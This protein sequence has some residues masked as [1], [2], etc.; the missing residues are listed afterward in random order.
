M[1]R[2]II[3][4]AALL[5]IFSYSYS[6]T[7]NVEFTKDESTT[8][9]SYKSD[10]IK[11]TSD[12]ANCK[13]NV[14]STALQSNL[15]NKECGS[16]VE[17]H[18]KNYGE[19]QNLK[20]VVW[21]DSAQDSVTKTVNVRPCKVMETEEESPY[22]IFTFHSICEVKHMEIKADSEF[23]L[24][25][26]DYS[27][28][29]WDD[30]H[31]SVSLK[32]NNDDSYLLI[33]TGSTNP[34]FTFNVSGQ[35]FDLD[36]VNELS[37]S[38]ENFTNSYSCPGEDV[39]LSLDSS[40]HVFNV[41][42]KGSTRYP[43]KINVT[44][45]TAGATYSTDFN[46]NFESSG[47]TF[48]MNGLN[49][50]IKIYWTDGS[51]TIVY[52]DFIYNLNHPPIFGPMNYAIEYNLVEQYNCFDRRGLPVPCESNY[53]IKIKVRDPGVPL[54]GNYSL[55]LNVTP[56][57]G[58]YT[59]VFATKVDKG[60]Y[61][62]NFGFDDNSSELCNYTAYSDV[63]CS[64]IGSTTICTSKSQ[65]DIVYIY[66]SG[67]VCAYNLTFQAP[68][69]R[70]IS[71]TKY[72]NFSFV[73]IP[74]HLSYG[75]YNE[76]Q[77]IKKEF[78]LNPNE[79][80]YRLI[81]GR[82]PQESG[83]I[84]VEAIRYRYVWK[85]T[86]LNW[87]VQ[88][89]LNNTLVPVPVGHDQ[90]PVSSALAQNSPCTGNSNCY[91]DLPFC[92]D[93]VCDSNA[94]ENCL[95]CAVDCACAANTH[96]CFGLPNVKGFT[97]SHGCIIGYIGYE[98]NCS[99]EEMCDKSKGLTCVFDT[100]H[101]K[102]AMGHCCKPGEIWDPDTPVGFSDANSSIKGTCRVPRG[103]EIT[104]VSIN[105][106]GS[107][108]FG[109]VCGEYLEWVP[110]EKISVTVNVENPQGEDK[111]CVVVATEPYECC[112]DNTK[113]DGGAEIKCK[114]V[115]EG[116]NTFTFYMNIRA[117]HVGCD[118]VWWDCHVERRC[119]ANAKMMILAFIPFNDSSF[120]SEAT[121][122]SYYY[123]DEKFNDIWNLVNQTIQDLEDS[124]NGVGGSGELEYYGPADI[125]AADGQGNTAHESSNDLVSNIDIVNGHSGNVLA[126]TG[127]HY[128]WLDL[129]VVDSS[130]T[131]KCSNKRT[132][133]G[134]I[135][136]AYEY[137]PEDL[138]NTP[139][140]GKF[141]GRFVCGG[142]DWW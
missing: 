37:Y 95:T 127:G 66:P 70:I 11:V 116:E 28:S 64:S 91:A 104:K 63:S 25:D 142:Y 45:E 115:H 36:N 138:G 14:T 99:F 108:W 15:T 112:N 76:S 41:S 134:S 31:K 38:S 125:Y 131:G 110:H 55:M 128:K 132:A 22:E 103:I 43:L 10:L 5:V 85:I 62:Y 35:T 56:A 113:H 126:D 141:N 67:K 79:N 122:I 94:G 139:A 140:K 98:G 16:A 61:W 13:F 111:V 89:I 72:R 80:L 32:L 109:S 30:G 123:G 73:K 102:K 50:G 83:N 81:W 19:S 4:L 96:G 23:Y 2:A 68:C 92:G 118:L 40:S 75:I 18:F 60:N 119:R 1:K 135:K 87:F 120:S 86:P 57:T 105:D 117:P 136:D 69:P 100:T 46:N 65:K 42:Y 58:G 84:T 21:N 12:I 82:Y 88:V 27:F 6:Y 107:R 9:V 20:I 53:V 129:I 59:D 101:G 137:T 78:S 52:S 74:I 39:T 106:A 47:I 121:N 93:G 17:I 48:P 133:G 33:A 7:I 71:F 26:G 130:S 29:Q 51:N 114:N 77:E 44:D 8:D 90:I 34:N 49:V 54:L 97:D 24:I 3:L 124:Y